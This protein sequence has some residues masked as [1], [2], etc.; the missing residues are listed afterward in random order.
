[1]ARLLI[2]VDDPFTLNP[3]NRGKPI[4][5]MG[6]YV[7]VEIEGR[8][9]D[10]VATIEREHLREGDRLW[11]M[12]SDATLE[13]RE[14]DIVFRGL[15]EVFVADG[16]QTGEQLVITDLAAPVAGMPLRNKDN[17]KRSPLPPSGVR[18]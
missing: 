13:I 14:I 15:N 5:L 6:S 16:V 4:M 8:Q 11:I 17:E 3:E 10:Q 18:K 9:L 12:N 7:R 1:M 2:E